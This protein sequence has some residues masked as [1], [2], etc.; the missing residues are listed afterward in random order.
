MFLPAASAAAVAIAGD[1]FL[2][3]EHEANNILRNVATTTL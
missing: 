1:D 3:S 2:H